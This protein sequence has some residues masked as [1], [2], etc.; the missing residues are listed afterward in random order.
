MRAYHLSPGAG[1]SGLVLREQPVPNPAPTE[2]LVRIH[3][4][5]LN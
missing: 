2:A 3:A 5:A 4:S 1:V